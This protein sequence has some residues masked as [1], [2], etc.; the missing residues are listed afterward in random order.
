ML[1]AQS[2]AKLRKV[3]MSQVQKS[4][5]PD[6]EE[7]FATIFEQVNELIDNDSLQEAADLLLSLHHADLADFLDNT[8][9]KTYK[10]ILPYL[11]DKL[12]AETLVFVN[13][14]NQQQIIEELGIEKSAQLLD[15]LD[16]EDAI[17]VIENVDGNIKSEIISHLPDQKRLQILEGFTYP[18]ESVGRVIEKNYISFK[19]H[20]SV[21]EA[22][23]YIRSQDI[24]R[25]FHAALI[26]D[27]KN[28]PVGSILLSTLLKNDP[29]KSLKDLMNRNLNA[30]DPYTELSE[31]AFIFKQYALTIV[32]VVSKNGKLIGSVSIDNMLYIIEE[33]AEKDIMQLGGVH[34]QDT[35][36]NLLSTAKHRFP[37]L[38][39]NLITA[40]ITS[41]IINHFSDTIAKSITIAAIMQIVASMGGNAGTQAM[42]VTVRALSNKDINQANIQKVILKEIS[43]C[44]LNGFILAII[45]ASLCMTIINHIELS[46][47]FGAAITINFLIAGFFGSMIPITLHRFDIDP[48]TTSG[49]FLTA[50]T[51]SLGFLTFLSLA[52]IFLG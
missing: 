2:I 27:N 14:S 24:A 40:C 18:A 22:T 19:E 21:G 7:Q 39:M 6:H 15:E 48:A 50:L 3:K 38:F 31:I 13:D 52:Y 28:R 23:D 26:I 46:I 10:Q 32:P 37:W 43:V 11:A 1:L 12:K 42:T 47:I 51:D 45:G 9:A 25:D 35:F 5:L 33:Q 20:W 17:E 36:Y 49:V 44:G 4:I 34:A 41:I 30:A 29:N 8:P 16:I